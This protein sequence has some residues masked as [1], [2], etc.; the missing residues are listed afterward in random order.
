VL[1]PEIAALSM[2]GSS[3][4]VAVNALALRR[5]VFP[6]R[7]RGGRRCD[8]AAEWLAHVMT[9]GCRLVAVAAYALVASTGAV[10]VE[11]QCPPATALGASRSC[12]MAVGIVRASRCP[13]GILAIGHRLSPALDNRSSHMEPR[14][15]CHLRLGKATAHERVTACRGANTRMT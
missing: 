5:Y 4:I 14:R 6:S 15:L 11:H 7:R 3:L 13:A 10:V 9:T 8:C 2:S 1:R 12:P